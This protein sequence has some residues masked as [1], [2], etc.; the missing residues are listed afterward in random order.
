MSFRSHLRRLTRSFCLLTVVFLTAFGCT[1]KNDSPW[2]AYANAIDQHLKT[3][4]WFNEPDAATREEI[5]ND[6]LR[7]KEI[8]RKYH[9][10]GTIPNDPLA[11][12]IYAGNNEFVM[13]NH[14]VAIVLAEDPALECS[15]TSFTK[16]AGGSGH[17]AILGGND[18]FWVDKG[19]DQKFISAT[20]T[21]PEG[22]NTLEI[23][24]RSWSPGKIYVAFAI[25]VAIGLTGC[26]SPDDEDES[27][28]APVTT[29]VPLPPPNVACQTAACPK[30][31]AV[32][33]IGSACKAPNA[34]C[35]TNGVDG[36]CEN[37]RRVRGGIARCS[38]LCDTT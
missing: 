16:P 30:G 7:A 15:G 22:E 24:S 23:S 13:E 12:Y 17:F 33:T 31:N 20:A 9:L 5:W 27:D 35:R 32:D 3:Y 37:T 25:G 19:T 4:I 6:Y 21:L 28:T 10:D 26:D 2:E 38:C 34:A 1:K 29:A 18:G 8:R 11:F 14:H 36:T